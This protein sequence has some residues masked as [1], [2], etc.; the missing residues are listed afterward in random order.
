M[1]ARR[2][3]C[4]SCKTS[5]DVSRLTINFHN[6]SRTSVRKLPKEGGMMAWNRYED[7]RGSRGYREPDYDRPSRSEAR[8]RG[9]V[10]RGADEVRSWFGDEEAE[11]RRRREMREDREFREG[12]GYRAGQSARTGYGS[13]EYGYSGTRPIQRSG[14]S[15]EWRDIGGVEQNNQ[16]SRNVSSGR[17]TGGLT[18][19]TWT[20][21]EMWLIPGP[22]VGRGPRGYRRS[23]ERIKEDVCECLAQHGMIDARNIDVT[24][25]NGEVTLRGSV[26]D[27][28]MKRRA[29][30]AVESVSGV[31]DVHNEIRVSQDEQPGQL[32]GAEA[33]NDAEQSG[34]QTKSK[35]GS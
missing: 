34:R 10:E 5:R 29:E 9:M 15:P 33:R 12:R 19:A 31:R 16:S 21:T 23:D 27:R 18:P 24:V 25:E 32:R 14:R 22:F 2:Q 6:P 28:Q 3:R 4:R 8:D 17:A 20:Y 13:E 26:E 7:E 1:M 11:Q 35:A 30:D